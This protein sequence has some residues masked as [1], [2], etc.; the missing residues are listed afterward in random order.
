MEKLRITL[1]SDEY[2][3]LIRLSE[4][5]RRSISFQA[6]QLIVDALRRRHL[7]TAR[8]PQSRARE[9]AADVSR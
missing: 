4:R 9:V 2:R 6:E 8:H 5:E 1:S 7:L 3:A